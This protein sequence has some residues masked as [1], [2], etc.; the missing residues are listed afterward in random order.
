MLFACLA[1]ANSDPAVFENPEQ[2]D[3]RRE[4]N[5]HLAFGEGIHYCLG[6]ALARAEVEIALRR[7]FTRFPNLALAVPRTH[8]RFSRRFG[9]RNLV[10]LP[11]NLI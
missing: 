9:S 4:P 11:L 5:R 8:V 3:L 6:A 7:L 2:L 10:S 1:A